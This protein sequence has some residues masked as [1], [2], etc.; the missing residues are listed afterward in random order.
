MAEE[1]KQKAECKMQE[2]GSKRQIAKGGMQKAGD[3]R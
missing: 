2:A 1:R 3:R